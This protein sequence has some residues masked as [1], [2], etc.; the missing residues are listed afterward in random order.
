[1]SQ[2]PK[3][4]PG[5]CNLSPFHIE[6]YF[7]LIYVS[8]LFSILFLDSLKMH[9]KNMY[10]KHIRKW[11]NFEWKRLGKGK[12]GGNIDPFY[13]NSMPSLSPESKAFYVFAVILFTCLLK[14]ISSYPL[15]YQFHTKQMDV[16]VV[17]LFVD[18]RTTY[19]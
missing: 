2:T 19:S 9:S 7:S 10:A 4:I 1:M 15:S 12:V 3:N 6:I 16:I 13:P 8:R 17:C 11:L 5:K 18:M 14:L